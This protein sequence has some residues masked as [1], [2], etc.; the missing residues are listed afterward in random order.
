[1]C[2]CV[3]AGML[4]CM[5]IQRPEADLGM[6]SPIASLHCFWGSLALTLSAGWADQQP[7]GSAHFHPLSHIAGVTGRLW[8][9]QLFMW[10]LGPELGFFR[11]GR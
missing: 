11:L 3:F 6:P 1:M 7:L 5:G 8:R 9:V 4:T 2:R 10:A